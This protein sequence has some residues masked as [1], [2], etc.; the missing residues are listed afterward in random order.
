MAAD[1]SSPRQVWAKGAG[2]AREADFAAHV[3]AIAHGRYVLR[4]ILHLLVQS[5]LCRKRTVVPPPGSC[6]KSIS[7]SVRV[8]R[9]SHSHVNARRRGGSTSV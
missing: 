2:E 5:P 8:V 9:S 7:I 1:L 6:T 3:K 4:H